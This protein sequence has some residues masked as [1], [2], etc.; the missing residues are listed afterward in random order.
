MTSSLET[1]IMNLA[2]SA[3]TPSV[4]TNPRHLR[5]AMLIDAAVTG[6]NGLAYVVAATWLAT[7]L[8]PSTPFLIGIGVF[9]TSCALVFVLVGR[10]RSIPAA[11]VWFAI[12]VNAA[13]ALASV[14]H[15]STADWLTPVGR[16][17]T[18]LQGLVVLGFAVAQL[19]CWRRVR[20]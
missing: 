6:A 17:W 10:A 15:A 7:L 16:V 1:E 11:G 18:A 8:G 19:I 14:I 2:T 3:P 20:P 13:W 5:A 4:Q 12:T 9:L